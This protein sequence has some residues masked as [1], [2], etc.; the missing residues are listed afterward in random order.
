MTIIFT[1]LIMVNV[2]FVGITKALYMGART[3]LLLVRSLSCVEPNARKSD[4]W[5]CSHYGG[6]KKTVRLF[7]AMCN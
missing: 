2:L 6:K 4:P 5:Q 7:P 1:I 3:L